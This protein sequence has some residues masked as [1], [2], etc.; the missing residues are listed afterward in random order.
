[1]IMNRF[2]TMRK[3]S[4]IFFLS[5][6]KIAGFLFLLIIMLPM[7]A[8]ANSIRLKESVPPASKKEK[9]RIHHYYGDEFYG[10]T[11]RVIIYTTSRKECRKVEAYVLDKDTR[12]TLKYAS[13]QTNFKFNDNSFSFKEVCYVDGVFYCYMA[14]PQYQMLVFNFKDNAK[15]CEPFYIDLPRLS[16]SKFVFTQ[17]GFYSSHLALHNRRLNVISFDRSS[18]EMIRKYFVIDD[19]TCAKLKDIEYRLSKEVLERGFKKGSFGEPQTFPWSG[20]AGGTYKWNIS[21]P[22]RLSNG[23]NFIIISRSAYVYY[24]S[25]YK[26]YEKVLDLGSS[27]PRDVEV[28]KY[29]SDSTRYYDHDQLICFFSSQSDTCKSIFVPFGYRSTTNKAPESYS[30]VADDKVYFEDGINT[31]IVSPDGIIQ[32]VARSMK[33]EVKNPQKTA[34]NEKKIINLYQKFGRDRKD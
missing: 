33:N 29:R 32:T 20:T 21:N 16:D 28:F 6:P 14:Y 9:H 34:L 22:F 8:T 4:N 15:T 2:F 7:V 3:I 27:V 17:N 24:E 31:Y 18:N 5:I 30:Y 12:D 11:I 10:N 25:K 19:S 23:T 26:A 13:F 1:M